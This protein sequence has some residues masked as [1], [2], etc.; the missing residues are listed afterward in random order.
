M[1]DLVHLMRDLRRE[2]RIWLKHH[3]VVEYWSS[4]AGGV[5]SA[6]GY[7]DVPQTWVAK[8]GHQ[9]CQ[10]SLFIAKFG[11]FMGVIFKIF[12]NLRQNVANLSIFLKNLA[13]SRPKTPQIFEGNF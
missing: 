11:I 6:S 1:R 7:T 13:N 2:T 10:W 4:T 3:R 12:P 5:L 9:V 8:S